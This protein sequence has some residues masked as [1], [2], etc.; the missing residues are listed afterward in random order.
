VEK[1]LRKLCE[2]EEI[3]LHGFVINTKKYEKA[4]VLYG[5]KEEYR[6]KLSNIGGKWNKRLGGWLFS[7]AK[8]LE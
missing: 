4:V 3:V 5:N 7:K 1:R 8:L 2:N 6:I